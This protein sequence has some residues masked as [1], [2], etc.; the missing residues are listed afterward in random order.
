MCYHDDFGHSVWKGAGI[1]RRYP[2][3]RGFLWPHPLDGG[4]LTP[5]KH[6]PL[7]VAYHVEVD[8]CW[9][10]RMYTSSGKLGT[11]RTTFQGHSGSSELTRVNLVLP[12]IFY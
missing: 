11:S 6:V 7:H 9:Y 10:E 3:N 1:S 4:V 8:R 5:Y 2:Q 12:M